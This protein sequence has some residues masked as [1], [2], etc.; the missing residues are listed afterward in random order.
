MVFYFYD[1]LGWTTVQFGV[2]VGVYGVAMVVGQT[3]LG[4]ASDR[5]GRRPVI[6]L[7]ML[8]TV[9]FYL[10]LAA[11][12]WFPLTL[13]VAFVAGLG[14]ALT[15]PAVSA[16]YL[17]ITPEQHRSRI[18]GIKESAAALGGVAG[19]LAVAA[20]SRLTRPQGIFLIASGLM[21]VTAGLALI[22]LRA[23]S[24]APEE[25]EDLGWECANQRAIAAQTALRGV[26]M[27][28]TSARMSRQ[29]A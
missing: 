2:V 13:L 28:A 3:A 27:S 21:L 23:P 5:F 19:P 8:L 25:A 18:L 7:G 9:S 20:V 11:V 15:S 16:F 22:A 12:T 17:D 24:R 6:V 29:A 1:Q 10:G 4:Q 26:V 14:M